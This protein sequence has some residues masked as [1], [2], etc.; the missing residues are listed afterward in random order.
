MKR[1]IK[2]PQTDVWISPENN[3]ICIRQIRSSS[4]NPEYI[5]IHPVFVPQL[6]TWLQEL[7]AATQ[8]EPEF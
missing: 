4:A 7:L 8:P 5:E 2:Q 6:I 3:M 1:T